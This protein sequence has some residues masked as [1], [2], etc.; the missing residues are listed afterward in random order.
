[1]SFYRRLGWLIALVGLAAC[2]P[3]MPAAN[4]VLTDDRGQT[5]SLAE[6]R[7]TPVVLT[8]GFTHCADTCPETL[9]KLAHLAEKMQ[10]AAK[11][12][13]IVMVSVDPQRD[14]PAVLHAF[15]TRFPPGVVGLTG[16]PAQIDAVKAAYHVWSQKV[17]GP[18]GRGNYDV[19]HSAVMFFIDA[20]GRVRGLGDDADSQ[21]SMARAMREL[22]G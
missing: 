13:E 20:G 16:T 10:D 9:A 5:W 18:H 8:F 22:N 1:M 14:T 15:V 21:A 3:G 2:S 6:Q 11:R 7:G 17:P 4:V 12:P 19:A